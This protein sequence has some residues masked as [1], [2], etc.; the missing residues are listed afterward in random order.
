VNAEYVRPRTFQ[1]RGGDAI[2]MA[3][4][5]VSPLDVATEVSKRASLDAWRA[6]LPAYERALREWRCGLP[7]D[8]RGV[9]CDDVSVTMDVI[10]FRDMTAEEYDALYD[11]RTDVSLERETVDALMAAARG[12]VARNAALGEF[13]AQ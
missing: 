8:G 6:G 13:R 4:M 7:V 5:I 3:E 12:V 2:G 11:T 1:Q 10:T 9:R